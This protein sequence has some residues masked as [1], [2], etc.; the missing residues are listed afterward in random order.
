MARKK[1]VKPDESLA[2]LYY[3][4][5]NEKSILFS[6]GS[7]R[8]YYQAVYLLGVGI[9]LLLGAVGIYKKMQADVSEDFVFL[10]IA[11]LPFL[12]IAWF[13]C[14]LYMYW[15]HHMGRLYLDYNDI[16]MA[17]RLN[18]HKKSYYLY[19]DFVGVLNDGKLLG[20]NYAWA[21]PLIIG[22][23]AIALYWICGYI[24]IEF[25][26]SVGE[27]EVVGNGMLRAVLHD[28]IGWI[29]PVYVVLL[30]AFFVTPFAIQ[31]GSGCREL[32]LKRTLGFPKWLD[33]SDEGK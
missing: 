20:V 29:L 9:V 13:S 5:Q 18:I 19:T 2:E 1:P 23:P 26:S 10:A 28:K 3:R 21:L 4:L 22:F 33:R 24:G 12:V 25:F 27:Q 31:I 30:L 6:E 8:L 15:D 16:R 14:F 11:G 7:K 32:E 17:R